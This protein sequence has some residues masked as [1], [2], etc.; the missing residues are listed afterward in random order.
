MKLN[1]KEY[2]IPELTFNTICKLEK[3]GVNLFAMD[4]GILGMVRGMV[5]LAMDTDIETAGEE[6]EKHI[7]TGGDLAEIMEE[8]TEVI[9]ES[10][11]FQSVMMKL[12]TQN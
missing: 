5:A 4:D 12:A 3:K 6:I 10:G 7:A 9:R 2:K 11:F 1:N 8:A